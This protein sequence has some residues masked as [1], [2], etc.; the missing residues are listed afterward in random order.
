MLIGQTSPA[1][2]PLRLRNNGHAYDFSLSDPAEIN[3]LIHLADGGTQIIES[4]EAAT[5]PKTASKFG[6]LWP[7]TPRRPAQAGYGN[8]SQGSYPMYLAIAT[9][10]K[11][12]IAAPTSSPCRGATFESGV[13]QKWCLPP[14]ACTHL[15]PDLAGTKCSK[16]RRRTCRPQHH[17]WQT[18]VIVQNDS[19][20]DILNLTDAGDVHSSSQQRTPCTVVLYARG[21]SQ[22]A[23]QCWHFCPEMVLIKTVDLG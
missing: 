18:V 21:D 4:G 14:A 11:S 12:L 5:V 10:L 20:Q 22:A 15:V 8:R 6:A 2:T 13:L 9:C 1:L 16:H 17:S 23:E 19:N 7:A 3:T